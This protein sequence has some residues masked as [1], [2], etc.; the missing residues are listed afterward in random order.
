MSSQRPRLLQGRE[1]QQPRNLAERQYET[2]SDTPRSL[3]TRLRSPVTDVP[4]VK[5]WSWRPWPF[6]NLPSWDPGHILSAIEFSQG[7]FPRTHLEDPFGDALQAT[8]PTHTSTW[9]ILHGLTASVCSQSPKKACACEKWQLECEPHHLLHTQMDLQILRTQF[10]MKK[11][12][13]KKKTAS[14]TVS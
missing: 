11:E 5:Y 14:K 10:Q 7:L 13:R 9:V 12:E 1:K 8:E 4:A 2:H 3:H 6:F